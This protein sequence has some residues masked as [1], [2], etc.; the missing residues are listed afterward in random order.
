[1]GAE[2]HAVSEVRRFG[3][4]VKRDLEAELTQQKRSTSK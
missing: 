1:M 4:R 2:R 3:E